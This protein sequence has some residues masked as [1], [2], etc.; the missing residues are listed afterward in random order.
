M[1]IMLCLGMLEDLVEEPRYEAEQI[2]PVV[3]KQTHAPGIVELANGDLL[4]SWYGDAED[5]DAAV[6]GAR[7]SKSAETWSDSFVMADRRGFPDC[8][9]C[10]MIDGKSQLWLFW[11]TIVGSSWESCLMNYR[12]AS[13][14]QSSGSPKWDREGL[15]LLK[16]NDFADEAIQLLGDRKL[17]PPRG[18]IGG[19]DAQLAKL[20]DPLYQRMGWAPRCK[21][22]VLPS[23]RILLPLYTDTFAISI[24]AISDDG[25][26]TWYPSKPLIGFGNIQPTVL[27]RNNGTLV[28][29]MRENGPRGCIRVSESSDEGLTWSPVGDSE[30]PNPG[31]GIDGVRLDNGHWVL[32]YNDSKSS[33]ASLVVS[34]SEN[35]GRTWS[36]TRHL[37]NH[38]AGRYHYPAVIQARDGTIHAIYSCFI[39]SEEPPVDGRKKPD[40]K[41]IKH[42]AFNEAWIRA[43]NKVAQPN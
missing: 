42:V 30:I 37:E 1:A 31:S 6:L 15:I 26:T 5:A 24:M 23:G 39:A 2:F 28:A 32:V 21:P 8:N 10:M 4:A 27:R 40:M 11:P 25:G 9:T 43:G 35:E 38:T 12:V 41:G 18:A 34:I 36:V 19:P 29:Y 7:K 14:Y 33:R 16:L 13:N 22:T 3:E 17:K 20:R